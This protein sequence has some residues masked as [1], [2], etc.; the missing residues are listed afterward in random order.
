VASPNYTTITGTFEDGSGTALS[1]TAVFTPSAT[2]YAT[3]APLVS[4][5]LPV[6]AKIVAGSLVSAASGPLTLLCTDNTGVTV[7]GS[8]GFWYWNVTVTV[9]G[10]T[11][12]PF[13]FLL[14][15]S[16]STV[17][18]YALTGTGSSA[19]GF[20]NPMTTLGDMISGGTAGV[21]TRVI[22]NT[23]AATAFLTG[24]GS[25]SA[26]AAPAWS[27]PPAA[28]HALA[29]WRFDVTQAA[30]AAAGNG[31]VVTDGAMNS[32][33]S[34]THLACTTSTPFAAGDVGKSII[35]NGAG[36]DSTSALV[37][38]I[39]SFTDSGHVVLSAACSTTVSGAAVLWATDDTAAIQAA[40][41]A[42]AAYAAVHGY[43]RVYRPPPPGGI[44]YGIAGP[45]VTT[46][47]ANSQL[48]I[49]NPTSN[50]A[51]NPE[52]TLE[53]YAE[54][55]PSVLNMWTQTSQPQAAGALVSFGAFASAGAYVTNYGTSGPAAV[56][57]S[58]PSTV[59]L[60]A[61]VDGLPAFANINVVVR[62]WTTLRPGLNNGLGYTGVNLGG[63]AK[64]LIEN[65]ASLLTVNYSNSSGANAF[66]NLSNFENAE[67]RGFILPGNGN[68]D[69]AV[70]RNCT[71][72]GDSFGYECGEHAYLDAC[73]VVGAAFIA[74][75]RGDNSDGHLIKIIGMSAERCANGFWI[76]GTGQ[77][78]VGF[79]IDADIDVETLGSNSLIQ[80]NDTGGGL[81]SLYGEIRVSGQHNLNIYPTPYPTSVKLRCM[82]GNG[83]QV[84]GYVSGYTGFSG[85]G[86]TVAVQNPY[87]RDVQV[88]F[89]G[90]TITV[91]KAGATLGGSGGSATTAPSMITT[92][93]SGSGSVLWPS[94]G[95]L[96]FTYSGSPTWN[97][98]VGI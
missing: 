21:A 72:S 53:F 70:A 14:P 33:A 47:S 83:G 48:T 26:A 40:I 75:L 93:L 1:G 64:G 56:L 69:M 84:P 9:G 27:L 20:S 19:G 7:E 49:P 18:L 63:C 46:G 62:N 25:G 13:S 74:E 97:V 24:T 61:N 81:G 55:G 37:T 76:S 96:S 41:N 11:L 28:R 71:T 52:Y 17:D 59:S 77:G 91:V 42:A 60:L 67:S 98:S 5:D 95:W 10:V 86:S 15:S 80:D 29:P 39:A 8:I 30:Y 6:N 2:V 38:T 85:A 23:S 92:G 87:W 78:G 73:R 89:S 68:N 82:G 43:A 58:T 36:A 31:Q 51:N 34:P 57:G 12:T 90:G 88:H 65:S 54:Q 4:A 44:F 22:G 79:F 3:G 16:P 32:G 35:V 66:P 50:T 45:L 94:G